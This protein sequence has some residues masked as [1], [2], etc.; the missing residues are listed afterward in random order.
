MNVATSANLIQESAMISARIDRLPRWG[1]SMPAKIVL[2]MAYFFSFYDILSIGVTLPNVAG[3]FHLT[4]SDIALPLTTSLAGYILGSLSLGRLADNVGR[5][6]A[7]MISLLILAVSSVACAFSWNLASISIFRFI[8]GFGIGSQIALCATLI[9][10]LSP[11]H[12]RGANLQF[13][14]LWAGIADA[15]TP[16]II[17]GF[18]NFTSVSIAW[19]LGLGFGIM[20]L[21]PVLLMIWLPESPRWLAT[22]GHTAKAEAIVKDME[23]RLERE[24]HK[25]PAVQPVAPASSTSTVSVSILL[26][27]PYLSR[28]ITTLAFWILFYIGVYGYLGFLTTLMDMMSSHMGSH[29]PHGVIYTAIGTLALPVGAAAPLVLMDK[30][31]RRVLLSIGSFIFVV[32]L[33]VMAL[34]YSGLSLV[35]GSAI[36]AFSILFIAGVGYTYTAEI[37]PTAVRAFAMG[38]SD[39]CGHIGG[40]IAPYIVFAALAAWGPRGAFGIMAAFMAACALLILILGVKNTDELKSTDFG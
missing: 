19:R 30:I 3:A 7:L 4:G 17:L 39:G 20:A 6:T 37:F 12:R 33:I 28:I 18:F 32:G 16:F 11:A 9:N 34:S 29:V 26:Q 31:H 36:V 27:K 23:D 15:S 22:R 24:G 35:L 10:E 21:I 1:I 2:I 25:L 13:N 14:I 5:K 40:V 8:V 38:I